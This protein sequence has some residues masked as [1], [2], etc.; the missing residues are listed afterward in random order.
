[1]GSMLEDLDKF[2]NVDLNNIIRFCGITS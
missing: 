1:M 2:S